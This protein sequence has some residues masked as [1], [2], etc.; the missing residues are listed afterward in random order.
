MFPNRNS[1]TRTAESGLTLMEL[2]VVIAIISV[3]A[4]LLLPALGQAREKA[5]RLACVNNLK[6][7]NLAIHLYADDCSDGLPVLADPNPYPNGVGAY[8]KQQVKGYVGLAGPASPTEKVFTCPA[9]QTIRTQLAHAFT[10]YTFNG[11]EVGQGAIPRITGRRL[12]AIERS[13]RAVLVAEYP[14]FWS[15]SWHPARREA[16][17]DA[18]SVIAFVDAHVNPTKIYWDGIAGSHPADY[19]PP[20]RYDY[21][22]DGQ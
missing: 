4:A 20:P 6:Q 19:E 12:S 3:L 15:G 10:S 11:Y 1:E 5:R 2:L 13:S 17:T 14:A 8:Y 22:W 9:D 16:S 21:S 18:K 7:I